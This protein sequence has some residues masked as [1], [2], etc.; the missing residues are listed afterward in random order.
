MRSIAQ[1]HLTRSERFVLAAPF[2]EYGRVEFLDADHDINYLLRSESAVEIER[3]KCQ[4]EALFDST[5]YLESE[6]V[7]L[8]FRFHDDGLDLSLAGTRHREGRLRLEATGSPTL[9]GTWS[10]VSDDS[11]RPFDQGQIDPFS[12]LGD[13]GNL[14]EEEG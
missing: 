14:G 11:P 6:T 3:V 13:M 12:D 9:V 1:A 10:Y 8:V 2:V 7:L 5:P 4:R